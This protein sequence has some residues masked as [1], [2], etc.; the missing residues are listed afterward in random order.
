MHAKPEAGAQPL[1][2]HEGHEEQQGPTGGD[3]AEMVVPKVPG[4]DRQQRDAEQDA[5]EGQRPDHT[6]ADAVDL[7]GVGDAGQQQQGQEGQQ[8]E[9][10]G[11]KTHGWQPDWMGISKRAPRG[12]RFGEK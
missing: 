5:G 11:Q 7:G 10:G 1:A 3:L 2:Q 12:A 8:A 6:Q 9:A 4:E